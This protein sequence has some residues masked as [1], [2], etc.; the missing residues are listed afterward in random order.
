MGPGR[1]V[2]FWQNKLYF[3]P[4]KLLGGKLYSGGK[5]LISDTEQSYTKVSLNG[6]AKTQAWFLPSCMVVP[7]Q[8]PEGTK[9]HKLVSKISKSPMKLGFLLKIK[10]SQAGQ[11]PSFSA[12]G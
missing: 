5:V 3:I 7:S 10:Q 2:D 6:L 9:G 12:L 8:G 4:T 11:I 1:L